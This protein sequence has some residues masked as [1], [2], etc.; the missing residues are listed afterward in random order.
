MSGS[1]QLDAIAIQSEGMQQLVSVGL[2]IRAAG[3]SIDPAARRRH[4]PQCAGQVCA[5]RRFR[6]R[7]ATGG[8]IGSSTPSF[9]LVQL[10]APIVGAQCVSF[11]SENPWAARGEVDRDVAAH[12]DSGGLNGAACVAVPQGLR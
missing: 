3:C 9:G 12:G 1:R 4:A 7:L 8:A 5:L 10:A 6:T 2:E 11:A